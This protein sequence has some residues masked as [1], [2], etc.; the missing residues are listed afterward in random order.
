MNNKT[1]KTIII[2]S[3]VAMD[4]NLART[5]RSKSEVIFWNSD[6]ATRTTWQRGGSALLADLVSLFCFRC[7]SPDDSYRAVLKGLQAG[8]SY[9]VSSHAGGDLGVFSGA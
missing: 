5:R 3:D 2:T 7:E 4:W 6:G 1:N 9:R 8:S